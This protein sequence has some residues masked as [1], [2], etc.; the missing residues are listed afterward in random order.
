M[1]QSLTVKRDV[2][3][4]FLNALESAALLRMTRITLQNVKTDSVQMIYHVRIYLCVSTVF[5]PLRITATYD[6]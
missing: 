5:V 1:R 4:T 6:A 3:S 2:W